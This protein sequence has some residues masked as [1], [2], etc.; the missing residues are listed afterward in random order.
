MT[1]TNAPIC[2]GCDQPLQ[3]VVDAD[4]QTPPWLCHNCVRGWWQAEINAG[5]AWDTDLRGFNERADMIL[6]AVD[7]EVASVRSKENEDA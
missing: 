5:Q 1:V 7:Q 3:A 4:E 6:A 2:P